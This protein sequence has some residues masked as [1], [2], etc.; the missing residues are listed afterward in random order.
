[1]ATATL[2]MVAVTHVAAQAAPFYWENINVTIDVQT[3]GDMLVTETQKYVFT[4]NYA[5]QRSRYIPLDKIQEIRDV[6]VEENNRTIASST[7]IE[8]Q[9]FW[10]RWEHELKP[11]ESH[12]FVLKY[13]VVG[14]LQVDGQN[15]LVYWKA[16]WADRKS[17]INAAKVTVQ[18]PESLSG[19]VLS[20]TSFGTPA[21]T[22]QVDA[23]S[24]EFAANQ[25]IQP[26]QELEVKIVFP[27]QILNLPESNLGKQGFSFNLGNIIFIMI[28]GLVSGLAINQSIA[29]RR[30]P[31]CKT[32]NLK[33][34][35]QVLIPATT[36][37]SGK[38]Q[39]TCK[40]QNC[41]YH[42]K[43]EEEIPV[44][45]NDSSSY[46]SSS[47]SS[48]SSDSSSSSSDSSSSSSDSGGGGGGGGGGD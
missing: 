2:F 47:S 22:R 34:T 24:F 15:T 45:R 1:M 44:I 16:I 21:I 36:S 3:N 43:Y 32:L 14:G 25:P 5:N 17:P 8:N 18:L 35:Y 27:K 37:Y 30:C 19:Q 46:S 42:N 26:Q 11:P 10:I 13:R 41:S 12:I 38:Q 7:G 33:R 9:Q 23:K 4:G 20:F 28:F 6:T 29:N 39:V 31:K 40:C 48:S